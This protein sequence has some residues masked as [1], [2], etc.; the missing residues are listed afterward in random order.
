VRGRQLGIV[1]VA[2]VVILLLVLGAQS[3]AHELLD[4]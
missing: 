3:E 2:L 4:A 1:L